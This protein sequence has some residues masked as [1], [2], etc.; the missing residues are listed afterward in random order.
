VKRTEEVVLNHEVIEE[1]VAA[2][3]E[4]IDEIHDLLSEISELSSYVQCKIDDLE[5]SIVVLEEEL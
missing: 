3:R 5:D 2:L 4:S 1:E